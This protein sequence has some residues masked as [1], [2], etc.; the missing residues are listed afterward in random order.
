[1]PST[2]THEAMISLRMMAV[3]PDLLIFVQ[4]SIIIHCVEFCSIM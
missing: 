4:K 1:M 3:N 2:H